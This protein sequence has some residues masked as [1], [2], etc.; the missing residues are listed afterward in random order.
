MEQKYE[1]RPAKKEDLP[2]ILEIYAFAR[3]FMAENGNPGQWGKT[4]PTSEQTEQDMEARKLYAVCCGEIIH[5]VFFFQ[6]GEEP[7]YREIY[8]GG[9]HEN[10][11]YGVIHR[12]AGD[13]SGGVFAAALASCREKTEYLRIDTHRDNAVMQHLLKKSGFRYCGRIYV[14]DGSE[15]LAYDRI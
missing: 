4:R 14:A 2:R 7:T 6:I 10:R 15:R 3:A 9:W 8:D 11:P 5:G 13:G 1:I 12:I